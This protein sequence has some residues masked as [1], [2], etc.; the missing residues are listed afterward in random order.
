L[1]VQVREDLLDH[2]RILDAGDNP[3]G[4]I[5]HDVPLIEQARHPSVKRLLTRGFAFRAIPKP[6]EL[7]AWWCTPVARITERR[8]AAAGRLRAFEGRGPPDP[9]ASAAT[10]QVW[11]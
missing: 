8:M 7:T 5:P 6:F 9:A 1:L 3:D 2:H 4:A 10:G 11:P